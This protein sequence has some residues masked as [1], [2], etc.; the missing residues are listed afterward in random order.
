MAFGLVRGFFL[1]G[2]VAFLPFSAHAE[3]TLTQKSVKDFIM[4]ENALLKQNAGNGSASKI[5]NYL[6][7]H[8]ANDFY[9]KDTVTSTLGSFG[10]STENLNYDRKEYIQSIAANIGSLKG[11]N[12]NITFKSVNVSKDGSSATVKYRTV[13]QLTA[14]NDEFKDEANGGIHMDTDSECVS[15]IVY[16]SVA[17]KMQTKNLVCKTMASM[18]LP[19]G[20]GNF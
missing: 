5:T 6:N 11:V 3:G 7:E 1:I 20:I 17:S 4:A 14:E 2:C 8:L 18:K 16:N 15:N 12:N 19:D 9:Y 13:A 10:S